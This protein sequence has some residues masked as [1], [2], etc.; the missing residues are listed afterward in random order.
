MMGNIFLTVLNMSLIGTFI[1]AVICLVRLTLKKVPKIISYCLWA[2]V[3]FRLLIP[4]TIESAMSL[5]PLQAARFANNI[6][7]RSDSLASYSD[8]TAAREVSGALQGAEGGLLQMQGAASNIAANASATEVGAIAAEANLW[9]N[10]ASV[11]A[12]LWL[13][14]MVLMLSYALVSYL[15]IAHKMR[16]ATLTQGNIFQAD[17]VKTPFVLGVFNP[18]IYLPTNLSKSERQYVILHEQTHIRRRDHIVKIV[19]FIALSLHWFNPF[20]WLAFRLMSTDMEMSCDEAVLKAFGRKVK[21]DYSHTLV[22]LATD[23]RTCAPAPLA[24]SE[25]GIKGRIKHIMKYKKS[26][27]L[28]SI[29]A[30][31]LVFALSVGFAVSGEYYTAED[32]YEADYIAS[33]MPID[34]Y[35]ADEAQDEAQYETDSYREVQDE[36]RERSIPHSHRNIWTPTNAELIVDSERGISFEMERMYIEEGYSPPPNNVSFEEAAKIAAR[37]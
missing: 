1:I 17:K 2:V 20:A 12:V 37:T 18:K 30:M 7:A 24:F 3:G 29:I 27:R 22:A 21:S 14:G 35:A 5:I 11:A 8:P 16:G 28:A 19:A 26:S 13:I 23:W 31:V 34:D 9:Q 4:V 15:I 10:P 33:E 36:Q 32:I 6:T 25:G